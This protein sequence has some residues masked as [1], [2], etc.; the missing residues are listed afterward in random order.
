M[1][2][3]GYSF[4]GYVLVPTHHLQAAF[5]ERMSE[6]ERLIEQAKGLGSY[7]NMYLQYAVSHMANLL[8][9]MFEVSPEV[10]EKRIRTEKLEELFP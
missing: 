5:S 8:A 2:Y 6:A 3:H 1:E 7:R 4:A 10:M 9:G